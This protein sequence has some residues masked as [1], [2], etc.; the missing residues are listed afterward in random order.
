MESWDK[1][2]QTAWKPAEATRKR[3][4]ATM[5][6]G[7]HGPCGNFKT[8][9]GGKG[10]TISGYQPICKPP[11]PPSPHPHPHPSHHHA[12]VNASETDVVDMS[13]TQGWT[14]GNLLSSPAD[15][16]DY[17]WWLLGPPSESNATALLT[18]ESMKELLTFKTE[19]YFGR[20]KTC[21]N[22][23]CFGYGLGMMNFTSMDWGK[24][25]SIINVWYSSRNG[26]E[27][28]CQWQLP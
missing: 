17:F 11:S 14:C 5:Q 19:N 3:L 26:S 22:Y 27:S 4:F 10:G 8:A 12:C 20:N 21:P 6:Y 15:V 7:V 2:D 18:P 13:S 1:L 16:A 23:S 9:T 28:N 25:R 24:M